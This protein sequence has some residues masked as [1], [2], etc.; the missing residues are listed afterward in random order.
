MN[1]VLLTIN[2]ISALVTIASAFLAMYRPGL[3]VHA[4]S[5]DANT[6]FYVYMYAVR[7]IPAGVAVLIAPFYFWGG[8]VV[9]LLLTFAVIQAGDAFI[10]WMRKEWGMVLFPSLSAAVHTV[11]A[12]SVPGA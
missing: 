1:P 9:L 10:G 11:V 6:R 3:M 2:T 12:F 4:S 8:A 7:A 5:V